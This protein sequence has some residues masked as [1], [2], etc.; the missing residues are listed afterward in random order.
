MGTLINETKTNSVA[1]LKTHFCTHLAVQS[2]TLGE[3][4]W[5]RNFTETLT[6]ADSLQKGGLV[7][8]S[9]LQGTRS[10]LRWILRP[11]S[12]TRSE[13]RL[14]TPLSFNTFT[15][16]APLLLQRQSSSTTT[17]LHTHAPILMEWETEN[18]PLGRLC[19]VTMA[20]AS[21]DFTPRSRYQP[22]A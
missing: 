20:I 18:H 15:I 10:P 22:K 6:L 12:C 11:G 4:L 21:N 2:V 19:C 7:F 5:R 9:S 16:C 14:K 1:P 17:H 13:R 3:L 8:H